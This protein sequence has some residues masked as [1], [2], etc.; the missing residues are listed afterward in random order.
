MLKISYNP[1]AYLTHRRNVRLGLVA[2]TRVL[3]VVKNKELTIKEIRQ[4]TGLKFGVVLYHLKL[5]ENEQIVQRKGGK[6]PYSWM[7]TGLGQKRLGE[8]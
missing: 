2:R 4:A 6:K 5:L 1:N 3:D 7:L 8:S